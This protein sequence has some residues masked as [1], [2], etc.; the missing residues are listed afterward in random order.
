MTTTINMGT[1][2]TVMACDESAGSMVFWKYHGGIVGRPPAA[3]PESKPDVKIKFSSVE[4]IDII[5]ERLAKIKEGM[6][7]ANG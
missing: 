4:S 1:G 3:N 7:V 6:Q 2:S 5:M